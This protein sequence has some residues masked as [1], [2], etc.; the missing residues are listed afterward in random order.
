MRE[1]KGEKERKNNEREIKKDEEVIRVEGRVDDTEEG[2]KFLTWQPLKRRRKT[3]GQ[4][5]NSFTIK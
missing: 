4:R 3:I 1:R 5:P 2:T